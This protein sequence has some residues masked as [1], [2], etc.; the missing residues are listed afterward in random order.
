MP[1]PTGWEELRWRLLTSQLKEIAKILGLTISDIPDNT[2][3]K[4]RLA[5]RIANHL[6]IPISEGRS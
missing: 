5:T 4:G 6:D 2:Q 3:Q 1:K